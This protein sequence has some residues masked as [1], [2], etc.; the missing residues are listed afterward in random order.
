MKNNGFTLAEVLITLG[1]IGVVA[2][3]TTPALYHNVGTA[4]IGPKLAKF[5]STVE[6]A[7]KM[8]LVENDVNRLSVLIRRAGQDAN[9]RTNRYTNLL[10][11]FMRIDGGA[12]SYAV[13]AYTGAG[14]LAGVNVSLFEDAQNAGNAGNNQIIANQIV[15]PLQN[16]NGD[17]TGFTFR[18]VEGMAVHFF[19]APQVAAA[20]AGGAA[21]EPDNL[22]TILVDI[23]S[24]RNPNR[25]GKDIF[26]F[27]LR[28]DGMLTPIG[29]RDV[30]S[31]I[32]NN[33]NNDAN[34]WQNS[35]PDQNGNVTSQ[36]LTCT[37]SIFANDLKVV[38]DE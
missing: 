25:L 32:N 24:N 19:L 18:T 9:N 21:T 37:G 6:N 7:N 10:Q 34:S 20:A 11:N 35:C 5:R 33:F 4:E 8:M 3:L 15:V 31:G 12:D 17:A 2:A 38:Y 26:G 22:G 28:N 16:D 13:Q 1:I 14:N 23:N 27:V 29:S 36:G 30:R